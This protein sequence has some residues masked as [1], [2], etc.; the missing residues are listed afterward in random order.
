MILLRRRLCLGFEFAPV[1]VEAR[2]AI[3]RM[4]HTYETNGHAPRAVKSA[5]AVLTSPED[6]ARVLKAKVY[7]ELRARFGVGI[8]QLTSES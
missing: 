6:M 8:I 3:E 5:A 2:G 7:T 1:L 4:G